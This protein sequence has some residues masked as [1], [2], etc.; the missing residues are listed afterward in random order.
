VETSS[1]FLRHCLPKYTPPICS[2]RKI[3]IIHFKHLHS[4]SLEIKDINIQLSFEDYPKP[5]DWLPVK[6]LFS[7]N[8]TDIISSLSSIPQNKPDIILRFGYPIDLRPFPGVRTKILSLATAEYGTSDILRSPRSPP[9][10]TPGNVTLMVPSHWSINLFRDLAEVPDSNLFHLPHGFDATYF[11]PASKRNKLSKQC[12]AL[13][14]GLGISPSDFIFLNTGYSFL[15][16]DSPHAGAATI[17]KN[18]VMLIQ[19]FGR[20]SAIYPTAV[21]LLKSLTDLYPQGVEN[22][23]RAVSSLSKEAV[24]RIIW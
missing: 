14:K 5:V 23:H 22:I 18:I 20:I 24:S 3:N 8:E 17:N 2:V 1:S 7:M 21:L 12:L 19:T 4:L 6:G 10:S 16:L 13:R 15:L 11:Y 9:W